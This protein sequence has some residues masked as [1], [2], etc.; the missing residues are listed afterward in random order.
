MHEIVIKEILGQTVTNSLSLDLPN[1][2]EKID[3][4]SH[5]QLLMMKLEVD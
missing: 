3:A 2:M 4:C 5:C 1:V